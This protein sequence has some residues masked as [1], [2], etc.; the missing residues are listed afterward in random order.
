MVQILQKLNEW[1]N[2]C[3]KNST[4]TIGVFGGGALYSC[5]STSWYVNTEISLPDFGDIFL[6][7]K[8]LFTSSTVTLYIY[9]TYIQNMIIPLSF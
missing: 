4:S 5:I 8:H 9:M 7:H 2:V 6:A 3:W 1:T